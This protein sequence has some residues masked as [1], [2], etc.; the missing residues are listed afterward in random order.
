MRIPSSR[1]QGNQSSGNDGLRG[2]EERQK[3][4][5]RI[6]ERYAYNAIYSPS[7]STEV[8]ILLFNPPS[9]KTFTSF[10][11]FLF[12]RVAVYSHLLSLLA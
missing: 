7:L 9:R 5:A 10:S 3:R 2:E 1:L 12:A 6:A 8:P 11:P 4:A